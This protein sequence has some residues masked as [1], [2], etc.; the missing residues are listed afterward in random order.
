MNSPDLYS[1][2][3][4]QSA[5]SISSVPAMTNSS[6]RASNTPTSRGDSNI[7]PSWFEIFFY[8]MAS[9]FLRNTES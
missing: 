4:L 6:S 9:N 8:N 3:F 1:V 2:F 7:L 5:T